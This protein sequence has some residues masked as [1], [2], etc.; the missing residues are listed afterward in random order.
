MWIK[1][2]LPVRAASLPSKATPEENGMFNYYL[3]LAWI[4]ISKT[5]G[6]VALMVG[7]IGIGIGVSMTMLTIYYMMD[8]DPI[9]WKSDQLYSVRVDNWDAEEPF[10]DERPEESPFQMTYLDATNIYDARRAFRETPMFKSWGVVEPND[11]ELRAENHILR[12]TGSDFFA[13]FDV[14]FLYGGAWDR[15]ADEAADRVVVLSRDLNEEL[16]G[17]VDSVGE[18]LRVRGEMF[19]VVGVIDEWEPQ[20]KYYD[21]N[22]GSFDESED[23]FLP[24]NLVRQ[25]EYRSAGNNNCYE[26]DPAPGWEGRLAGECI[27]I[28]YWAELRSPI[29]VEDYQ[30]FLN[31]YTDTQRDMGRFPRPNN[32]QLYDVNEWLTMQEVVAEDVSVTLGL[33]A[34]FLAVCLFNT[35]GLLLAKFLGKSA[36]TGIRR[37]LGASKVDVFRQQLVEVGLI[38]LAGGIAGLGLSFLGLKGLQILMIDTEQLVTMD[39]TL[40]MLAIVLALVTTVLAGLYPAWRVCQTPPAMY[41]KTQ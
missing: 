12:M 28:Q 7:A 24:F 31:S 21:L 14:P 13:M 2:P 25:A 15:T 16:F 35:V 40:V 6:L 36:E 23:I 37:A 34:L 11:P 10:W 3:R 1:P 20:P 19:R 38:G 8:R 4:S 5:P 17:G 18:Q 32:N 27:W 26:A 33:S 30:T 9:P 41:L 22:N 39:F 29:E